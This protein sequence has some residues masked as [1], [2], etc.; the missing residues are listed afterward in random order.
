MSTTSDL[1]E[2][3]ELLKSAIEQLRM[4]GK[5]IDAKDHQLIND[6]QRYDGAIYYINMLADKLAIKER[7]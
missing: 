3:K 6:Y 5:E 7:V 4:L 2:I 1:S